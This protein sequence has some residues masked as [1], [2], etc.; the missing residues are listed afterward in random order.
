M[1]PTKPAVVFQWS[2]S[3]RLGADGAN[4]ASISYPPRPLSAQSDT[5]GPLR[6]RNRLWMVHGERDPAVESFGSIV[7]RDP[8]PGTWSPGDEP[9]GPSITKKSYCTSSPPCSQNIR[10][11]LSSVIVWSLAGM[12]CLTRSNSKL[13]FNFSELVVCP[14]YNHY[15]IQDRST[16]TLFCVDF[17]SNGRTWVTA[18]LDS[19][20]YRIICSPQNIVKPFPKDFH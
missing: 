6:D 18:D 13:G 20:N 16:R 10:Q 9:G 8:I 5:L 19:S 7:M 15:L 1:Y 3:I 14:F 4:H 12:N 11:Q 17:S 2:Q